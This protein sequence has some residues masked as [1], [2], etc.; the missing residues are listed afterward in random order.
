M[1][2]TQDFPYFTKCHN[3]SSTAL[4]ALLKAYPNRYMA[5]N[6]PNLLSTGFPETFL[7]IFKSFKLFY[8]RKPPYSLHSLPRASPAPRSDLTPRGPSPVIPP[9]WA[10]PG[11]FSEGR[12]RRQTT[13]NPSRAERCRTAVPP[14]TLSTRAPREGGPEVSSPAL[15]RGGSAAGPLTAARGGD[16]PSGRGFRTPHVRGS[17]AEVRLP[18]GSRRIKVSKRGEQLHA[19]PLRAPRGLSPPG[20]RARASSPQGAPPLTA[21]SLAVA[22]PKPAAEL[23]GGSRREEPRLRPARRAPWPRHRPPRG[24]A[25]GG[26]RAVTARRRSARLRHV[27]AGAISRPGEPRPAAKMGRAGRGAAPR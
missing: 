14:G 2:T 19:R 7:P 3:R 26:G 20:Y 27:T 6:P 17:P 25:G 12:S 16:L 11:D 15:P 21:A 18:H 5:E 1:N 10:Q 4:K 24:G 9:A 23:E 8:I 22:G 13:T